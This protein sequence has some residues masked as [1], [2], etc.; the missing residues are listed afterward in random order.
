MD[1]YKPRPADVSDIDLPEALLEL[2]ELIA[3]NTHDVWAQRRLSE[4]WR[5]GQHKNDQLKE[6][7]CLVPYEQLPESE[8]EYDR[9]ISMNVL[10]LIIRL[11]Y[12]IVK[13]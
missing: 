12:D 3:K 9:I 4:G 13:R 7:P 6:T 10:R 11:G 1:N 8:K 5:Y 2:E